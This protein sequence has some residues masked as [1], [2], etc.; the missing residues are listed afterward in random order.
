MKI[1]QV[2]FLVSVALLLSL[3]AEAAGP[4]KFYAV[5]PCRIVDTWFPPFGTPIT[6]GAPFSFKVVGLCGVPLNAVAVFLTV[7]SASPTD[8]GYLVVYPNPGSPPGTSV[9]NVDAGE[10][11]LGNGGIFAL[12]SDSALQLTAVYGTCCGHRTTDLIVDVMG[13][14][15]P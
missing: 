1:K 7:T 10:R 4:T 2:I 11:A 13:Y 3:T 15:T 14:Y 9:V 6:S 8:G 5:T 12:G